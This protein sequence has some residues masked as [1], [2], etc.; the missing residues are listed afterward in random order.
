MLLAS[1]YSQLQTR[2]GRGYY[3][4]APFDQVVRL[5]QWFGEVATRRPAGRARPALV[6]PGCSAF[7]V[8]TE[9]AY[10]RPLPV[11]TVNSSTTPVGC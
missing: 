11:L 7:T 8:H 10:A 9:G 6:R 5:N 2:S 1:M 4:T 3:V